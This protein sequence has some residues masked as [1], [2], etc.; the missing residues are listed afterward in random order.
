LAFTSTCTAELC[1]M[2]DNWDQFASANTVVLPVSVD[3]TATLKEFKAKYGFQSEFLSD[4]KRDVS[5]EYGVL[6]D[7]R[8]YSN[9]AYILIDKDGLVRWTHVEANNSDKRSNE[10]IFAQIAALS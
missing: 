1:D 9:R 4:F 8:F 6:N 7:E 5:R 3:S 2:R 10:E